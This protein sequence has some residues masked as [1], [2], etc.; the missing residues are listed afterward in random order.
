MQEPGIAGRG[1]PRMTRITRMQS[2]PRIKHGSNTD[3]IRV[4]FVFHPWLA[5]CSRLSFSPEMRST[6]NF[7]GIK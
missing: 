3:R 1:K 7:R 4:T 6:H 5:P 2:E